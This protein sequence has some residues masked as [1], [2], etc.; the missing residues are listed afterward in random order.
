MFHKKIKKKKKKKRKINKKKFIQK[1]KLN[2]IYI[3]IKNIN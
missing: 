3:I 1:N 2:I